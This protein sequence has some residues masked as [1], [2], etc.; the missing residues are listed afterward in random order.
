MKLNKPRP[1]TPLYRDNLILSPAEEND[2]PLVFL[3]GQDAWGAEYQT[4]E[5]LDIC[6]QSEKYRSGIWLVLRNT[7]G[8]P[9]SSA[10]SYAI[11]GHNNSSWIGID[12]LATELNYRKKGYG[13]SCLSMLI[14]G[15]EKQQTTKGFMLFQDVQTKI[16]SSAGFITAASMGYKEPPPNLLLRTHENNHHETDLILKKT[17]SYF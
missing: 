17:P 9:I 7:N 8:T 15:H 5:Y 3:M 2:M 11:P 14:E 1:L 4:A 6:Y 12:S 16:Y 13:L 10:I